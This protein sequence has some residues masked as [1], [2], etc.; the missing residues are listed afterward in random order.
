MPIVMMPGLSDYQSIIQLAA[1]V[2][3]A[4]PITATMRKPA[5]NMIRRQVAWAQED[6]EELHSDMVSIAQDQHSSPEQLNVAKATLQI[7]KEDIS[8]LSRRHARRKEDWLSDDYSGLYKQV[9][10][11]IFSVI[12]LFIA[13]QNPSHQISVGPAHYHEM[14]I[15]SEAIGKAYE[16]F[17]LV[18][19]VPLMF[20]LLKLVFRFL[21]M[22]NVERNLER[23]VRDARMEVRDNLRRV[24]EVGATS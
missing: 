21:V 4:F 19:Y 13:V 22:R 8:D 12:L 9:I 6:L 20:S 2:N 16:I 1:G 10:A 24:D 7:A 14:I 15:V 3:L 17:C 23:I 11:S 18:L 5:Q